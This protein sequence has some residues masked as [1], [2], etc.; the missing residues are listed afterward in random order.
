MKNPIIVFFIFYCFFSLASESPCESCIQ[1]SPF[2]ATQFHWQSQIK[3]HSVS[4]HFPLKVRG[5]MALYSNQEIF[6]KRDEVECHSRLGLFEEIY[7]RKDAQA[8]NTYLVTRRWARIEAITNQLDY[9]YVDIPSPRA[10]EGF[11]LASDLSNHRFHELKSNLVETDLPTRFREI[12][13]PI[14]NQQMLNYSYEI[15]SILSDYEL[16]S[17]NEYY[18]NLTSTIEIDRISF[19]GRARSR[20]FFTSIRYNSGIVSLGELVSTEEWIRTLSRPPFQFYDSYGANTIEIEYW[21]SMD[22]LKLYLVNDKDIVAEFNL[23]TEQT[24]EQ[25]NGRYFSNDF[26]FELKM[27]DY[28][29]DLIKKTMSSSLYQ[30]SYGRLNSSLESIMTKY[31]STPAPTIL[32]AHLTQKWFELYFIAKNILESDFVNDRQVDSRKHLVET[33]EAHLDY[34]NRIYQFNPGDPGASLTNFLCGLLSELLEELENYLR[35]DST[36][37]EEIHNILQ[38]LYN[39]SYEISVRSPLGSAHIEVLDKLDELLSNYHL[40][41]IHLAQIAQ[42]NEDGGETLL[43]IEKLMHTLSSQR[44]NK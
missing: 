14:E 42:S 35:S 2:E 26:G 39:Q 15:Q 41:R 30:K 40:H 6:Y 25:F 20:K 1:V 3:K 18:P 44:T 23:D 37:T 22:F 34:V 11:F 19:F 5:E 9:T 28:L 4:I 13:I 8:Q 33:L 29:L 27:I 32:D 17:G 31:H 36:F 16:T 10:D 12:E 21:I 24:P 38:D 43:R 7:F